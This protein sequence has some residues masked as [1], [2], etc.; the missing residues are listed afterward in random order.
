MQWA[1][2]AQT[3]G[4][5]SGSLFPVGTTTNTF[6]TTDAAGNS[7]TCSFTVTVADDTPP[8][9]ICQS[10]TVNLDATGN[11]TITPAMVNNGSHDNCSP[12][13]LVS[14]VPSTF[15]CANVG[16]NTVTLTVSDAVGNTSTCTSTVT[17][18]D[19]TAPVVSCFGDTTFAKSPT[20]C[21][22]T[23]PDLTY[24]VTA[25]DACGVASVTQ[26]IPAG[27]IIGASQASVPITLTVT[28]VNGNTSTCSFTVFFTD[29]TPPV[30][31]GCPSNITVNTGA[32]NTA[33]S[34]TAT[35][36]EPTAMDQCP[37]P[38]GAITWT[39]SHLPGA[40]FP[41]GTTTVTYT[42]SDASGNSS[43]CSFTVTV[44]DNTVPII[45]NCPANITVNT[46]AGNTACSQTATW[47]APTATDNCGVQSLTSTHNSGDVF[48]A[49]VTT[50]TYTAL[51]I[52][53]NTSTCSFTV[54]VV[55]N[56]VPV[57]ADCPSNVTVNTGA[58]NTACSQT[59]TWTEPTATD[60]CGGTITW[61]K[62][63]YRRCIPSRTNN[64]N[65]CSNRC[66]R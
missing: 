29:Q 24:R 25:T 59:A 58:G 60:N 31:S 61:T 34:Q 50:V 32:G 42:V 5:A 40:T 37:T 39:K 11:A 2:T 64:G 65:V 26:S 16:A 1:T 38:L 27:T 15:T 49:G 51:D 43:T 12:V 30:I 10:I 66:S 17:I 63:H 8:V 53:G 7:A 41:V 4:L 47:T 28:D 6:V 19:V 62:S 57:I 33:C 52:H 23:L 22:N 13:T 45:A 54:T 9:S 48:P 44:V 14:V 56:T 20:L 55:D 18:H 46:G 36:T 3:A 35:W 21:T